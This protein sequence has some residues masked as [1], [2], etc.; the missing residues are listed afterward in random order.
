MSEYRTKLR[1]EKAKTLLTNSDYKIEYIAKLCG[2]KT[3]K[4]LRLILEMHLG[5]LP[6][7]IKIK[8]S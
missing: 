5:A 4:Q 6:S 1:I 3:S 2:Y 8:L 7:E